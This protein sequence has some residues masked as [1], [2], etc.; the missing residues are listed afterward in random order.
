MYKEYIMT[1][2]GGFQLPVSIAIDELTQ[3]QTIPYQLPEETAGEVLL[4]CA[5]DRVSNQM[6]AGCIQ[7][8]SHTVS[9]G[10]DWLYLEGN[11]LCLEMI[12]V[13]RQESTGEY[14]DKTG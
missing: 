1:L 7:S 2:P 3:G 13:S 6:T 11:F 9:R 8:E 5:A 14:H 10:D 12:G 4:H